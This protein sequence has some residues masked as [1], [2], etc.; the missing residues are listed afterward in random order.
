MSYVGNFTVKG[1]FNGSNNRFIGTNNSIVNSLNSVGVFSN[2]TLPNLLSQSS[3]GTDSNGVIIT[4][5]GETSNT[6]LFQDLTATGL[7]NFTNT[8]NALPLFSSGTGPFVISGGMYLQKNFVQRN[9]ITILGATGGGFSFGIINSNHYA[10]DSLNSSTSVSQTSSGRT[11][12]E[13]SD[14]ITFT[15]KNVGVPE[16]AGIYMQMGDL[17]GNIP[18]LGIRV[19]K[20]IFSE[21]YIQASEFVSDTTVDSTVGS[22]SLARS[23]LNGVATCK[24]GIPITISFPAESDVAIP[25]GTYISFIQLGDTV[26]LL[27]VGGTTVSSSS[28]NL[29]TSSQYAVIKAQKVTGDLWIASGDLGP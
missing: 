18:T 17:T 16:Y 26:T 3:L 24:N 29:S 10:Q 14:R 28:G 8:T 25:T 12:I 20:N 11:F 15:I 9:G 22:G 21:S 6:G 5:S 27:G 7:V 2:L 4:S 13:G 1:E 23:N 19:Y